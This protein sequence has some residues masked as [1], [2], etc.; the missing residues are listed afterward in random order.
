ME[1]LTIQ[2]PPE[3]IEQIAQWLPGHV[4]TILG[5]FAPQITMRIDHRLIIYTVEVLPLSEECLALLKTNFIHYLDRLTSYTRPTLH[6]L[7]DQNTANWRHG[8][9][10]MTTNPWLLEVEKALAQAGLSLTKVDELVGAYAI[11]LD[12]DQ[13]YWRVARAF[14]TWRITTFGEVFLLGEHNLRQ[15]KGIGDATIIELRKLLAE[16]GLVLPP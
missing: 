12:Y 9:R 1:Q 8:S 5:D 4:L 16:H 7:L 11:P 14:K 10:S 6:I 15:I 2:G 13:F 3:L